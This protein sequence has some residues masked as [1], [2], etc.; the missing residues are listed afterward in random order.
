MASVPHELPACA[1][2]RSRHCQRSHYFAR[3]SLPLLRAYLDALCRLNRFRRSQRRYIY[4]FT[5]TYLTRCDGRKPDAI[6]PA[7]TQA[8]VNQRSACAEARLSAFMAGVELPQALKAVAFKIRHGVDRISGP[9]TAYHSFKV[10][11]TW[12]ALLI[13]FLF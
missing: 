13:A 7:T 11:P 2:N 10:T 3:K 5:M 9:S 1:P 8:R 12:N 6:Q 4:T